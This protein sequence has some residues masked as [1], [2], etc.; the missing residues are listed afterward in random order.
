MSHLVSHL[1]ALAEA[2]TEPVAPAEPP[3]PTAPPTNPLLRL[4]I[5]VITAFVVYYIL[6]KMTKK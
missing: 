3:T 1:G 6:K 4:A 2:P 5:I